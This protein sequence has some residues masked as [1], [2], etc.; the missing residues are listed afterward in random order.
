MCADCCRLQRKSVDRLVAAW[1]RQLLAWFV[2]DLDPDLFGGLAGREPSEA[3]WDAQADIEAAILDGAELVLMSLDF[4]KNKASKL[5]KLA[6]IS[7]FLGV[8][9][10]AFIIFY[11]SLVPDYEACRKETSCENEACCWDY[12][13]TLN[14]SLDR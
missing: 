11:L 3:S 8:P 10:V 14:L 5:F 12:Q 6:K 4:R 2:A 1:Y 13:K 9:I 7:L